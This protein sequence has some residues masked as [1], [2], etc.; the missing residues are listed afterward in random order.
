MPGASG[1]AQALGDE[2]ETESVDWSHYNFGQHERGHDDE[3][4]DEQAHGFGFD[5]DD[6]ED[7]AAGV[8][9]PSAARRRRPAAHCAS[10]HSESEEH[11]ARVAGA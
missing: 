5:D 2:W 4:A 9:G 1:E 3:A 6:R 7:A 10:D 11:C 8:A